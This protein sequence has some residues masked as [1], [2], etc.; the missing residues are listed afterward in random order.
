MKPEAFY[1]GMGEAM[2]ALAGWFAEYGREED[3]NLTQTLINV[4]GNRIIELRAKDEA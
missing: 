2:R 1:E 3:V 4:I